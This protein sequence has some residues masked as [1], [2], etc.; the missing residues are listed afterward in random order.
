MANT[1]GGTP[2]TNTTQSV[3]KAAVEPLKTAGV[4]SLAIGIGVGITALAVQVAVVSGKAL[5]ANTKAVAQSL[6]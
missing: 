4:S 3:L 1:T 5:V 2:A 6:R